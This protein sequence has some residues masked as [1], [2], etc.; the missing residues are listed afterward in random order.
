[1]KSYLQSSI[2]GYFTICG[3]IILGRDA[4]PH[5][6]PSIASVISSGWFGDSH[7]CGAIIVSSRTCLTSAACCDGSS[8]SS[9]KV[10]VGSNDRN[11]GGSKL[12]VTQVIKHPN[13]NTNTI[14][15]NYC[16]LRTTGIPIQKG[17]VEIA[18][19]PSMDTPADHD[20]VMVSGWGKTDK[21]SDTLPAQLQTN[22][23]SI[24]EKG[25]CNS[26]WADVNPVT[27]Q[28]LCFEPA[29]PE[30][31]SSICDG[32]MGGPVLRASDG[33][34]LGVIS[35]AEKCSS[36]RP[37]IAADVTSALSWIQENI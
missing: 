26:I 9:L 2:L 28:M 16:L 7:I 18:P 10:R 36:V 19:L 25:R 5:E 20:P 32:D 23:F 3:A 37:N 34:V 8:A 14:D 24:V 21:A 22:S 31:T 29:A 4:K 33:A 13:W 35:H 1:M 15:S 6:V 27:H 12:Q 11:T 30:K 17:L